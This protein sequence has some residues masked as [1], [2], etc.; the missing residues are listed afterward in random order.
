[1]AS[2]TADVVYLN[3]KNET[4]LEKF[5]GKVKGAIVLTSP[6]REVKAHF[7]ALGTRMGE[8]DL[9]QLADAAGAKKRSTPVPVFTRTAG[10][11]AV[12]RQ[13]VSVSAG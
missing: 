3:A 4:E 5:K 2:V 8:K 12:S 10:R 1:M 11:P 13:E 7:E 9:L 6:L